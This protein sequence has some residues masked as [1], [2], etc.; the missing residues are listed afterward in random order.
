MNENEAISDEKHEAGFGSLVIWFCV[1]SLAY[2][3]SI[4]PAAWLHEKM[5][6]ARLRTGLGKIYAPVVFLIEQTPLK[7]P[8]EWWV[9]KWIDLPGPK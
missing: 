1:A 6:S 5:S 8:G 7:Q 3:L 2:V 4:G 9:G